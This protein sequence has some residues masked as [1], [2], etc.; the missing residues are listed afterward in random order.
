MHEF[1]GHAVRARTARPLPD[2]MIRALEGEHLWGYVDAVP[3]GRTVWLLRR[4]TVYPPGTT[5]V[6]RRLLKFHRDWPVTGA[7]VALFLM[8]ALADVWSIPLALLAVVLAYA[9]GVWVTARLTHDLRAGSHR[10]DITSTPGDGHSTRRD[11]AL[12]ESARAEL[13]RL[14]AGRQRGEL[15]PVEFEA[16]WA[17]VFD[18]LAD[19]VRE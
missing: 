4:L 7:V 16:G 19:R 18:Q 15:T 3:A 12:F 2:W 6:E 1:D 5:V 10:L 17:R 13:L 11:V 8:F 9:G 14:D